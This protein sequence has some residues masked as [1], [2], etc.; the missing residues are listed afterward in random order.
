MP[1]LKLH[2]LSIGVDV[3]FVDAHQGALMDPA[4]DREAFD[5]DM[6]LIGQCHEESKGPFF[7]VSIFGRFCKSF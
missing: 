2:F 3:S 7:I 1:E 6:K 5:R 4:L